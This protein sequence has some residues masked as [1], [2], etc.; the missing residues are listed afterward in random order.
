VNEAADVIEVAIQVLPVF[1]ITL[2]LSFCVPI[3]AREVLAATTLKR[4]HRLHVRM[5][6]MPAQPSDAQ[7]LGTRSRAPE[8]QIMLVASHRFELAF[9]KSAHQ[10]IAKFLVRNGPLPNS[11]IYILEPPPCVQWRAR[12]HGIPGICGNAGNVES[13]TY[14]I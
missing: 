6:L 10:P 4:D 9:D 5:R 11:I 13:V 14:R 8:L 3:S 1:Y 2:R 12:R 7:R